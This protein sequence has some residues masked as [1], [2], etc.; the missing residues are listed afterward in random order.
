MTKQEAIYNYTLRLGD[1]S[2]ILGHRLSELC[3]RGPILEEDLALTNISLDLI[4][5]TEAL[6]KYAALIEDKGKTENDLAYR[7]AEN[8]YYNHLITEQPNG[9]FAHTIARQL[10]ISSYEYLFYTELEK[11]SDETL[12]AIAKKTVKEIKYHMQHSTD[13]TIRLGDGTSESHDRMQKAINDL[14]MFTGELFEMDE[15][16]AQLLPEGISVDLIPLKTHWKNYIKTVLDEAT[17]KVPEDGYMQTGSRKGIHTEN[18][19]HI[20]SEM[21]YLQRAYPDAKW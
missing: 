2:L 16:E 11:S 17:L 13:W 6:L 14:W 7:R 18:L 20:L 21:Q 10:F 3:S 5:R 4:G 8:N 12:S 1:D 15:I 9:D 19:G